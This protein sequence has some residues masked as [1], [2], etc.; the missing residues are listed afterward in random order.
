MKGINPDYCQ[1]VASMTSCCLLAGLQG[2]GLSADSQ[3]GHQR[4]EVTNGSVGVDGRFASVQPGSVS[5]SRPMAG[6]SGIRSAKAATA[7]EIGRGQKP[8]PAVP[9]RSVNAAHPNKS[10]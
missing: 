4:L 6:G 5:N 10:P 3:G 8:H 1:E 9:S 7:R 2:K